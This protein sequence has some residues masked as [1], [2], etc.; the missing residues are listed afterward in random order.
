MADTPETQAL[1]PADLDAQA[2]VAR[3]VWRKRK[4]EGRLL[5]TASGLV[6]RVRDLTLIDLVK[7]GHIPQPLIA[8]VEIMFDKGK[9]T[10]DEAIKSLPAIEAVVKAAVVAP[11]V[12]EGVSDKDDEV[13][14]GEMT[15]DEK[16]SVVNYVNS[17]PIGLFNFLGNAAKS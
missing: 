11:K 13:G 15:V 14:L 9:L 8:A 16:L 2:L 3:R 7:A 1:T 6:L 4:R 17:A 12:V 10:M 5:Q